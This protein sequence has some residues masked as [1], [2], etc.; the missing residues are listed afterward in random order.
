MI[1][2]KKKNIVKLFFMSLLKSLLCIAVVLGVGFISYK[3]SYAIL[4]KGEGTV[5]TDSD[6]L[7]DI[8]D[9]ATTDEISRNLIY[10]SDDKNKV[11][12]VMLEICNTKTNNMDYITIPVKTN[13][14]IPSV[15]YRKLCQVNQEIPQ[16][17]RIS[18]LKQYFEDE[19]DAYGYGVLIF[20][21]MLGTDISY[22]TA[23]SQETYD[24]HYSQQNVKVA[25]K[26]KSSVNNTPGPDG[27]IPSSNTTLKVKMKISVLSDAYKRQLSDLNHD[28]TKIADYIKDQYERVISN[29]TVYNKIGYLEAY[30][31]MDVT[32]YHY[33]GIPGTYTDKVFEVD[34]KAAKKALKILME[35]TETYVETQDLTKLNMISDSGS[36]SETSDSKSGNK[37]TVASSKG[38]NIYVR[39][40]SQIAGLA[41]STKAKLEEA[42]Y[43][44]P[45]V[46]NYT[47]ETL[48]T[49]RIIVSKKGQGEDLKEYFNN[50]EISVGTVTSG[51]DIEIILGTI[52]AN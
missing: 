47:A 44:V 30:E 10:V 9:D 18:E 50:P 42:G 33:W 1:M 46:G 37:D 11:T 12:T 45:K 40:G 41:S 5:E 24:N 43:T 23:I 6:S 39:N 16:V 17:I 22:Y 48:T 31:K 20:E 13:Y 2:K 35:N 8:I 7:K 36:V 26:T 15:M 52:D 29:L 34:T 3:I 25:Y 49:T 19:S 4:S 32:K 27:T 14:T 21:K 51:Y 28:Q 38:L